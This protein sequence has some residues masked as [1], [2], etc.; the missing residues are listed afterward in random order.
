[1]CHYRDSRYNEADDT[2][3]P[4]CIYHY[5]AIKGSEC[6]GCKHRREP[7]KP[8]PATRPTRVRTGPNRDEW[9]FIP[10]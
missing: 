9:S 8:E 5:R 1:M 6:N 3:S 4:W 7:S 2:T 10:W